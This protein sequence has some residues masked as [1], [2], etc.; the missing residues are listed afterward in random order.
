FGL[1]E[2]R[3]MRHIKTVFLFFF[4]CLLC[5]I[6]LSAQQR[7]PRP[8]RPGVKEAGVQR[9]MSSVTPIAVFP[10]EGTPDWQVLTEDS[11]W[12]TNGPKN[13]I[14]R[15]DVKTNTVAAVIEVG[16]RPCSGLAAGF[17][18]IWVPNCGDNTLSRIDIQT[19]RVVAT[20]PYGP[21]NS[22]GGLATSP[23]SVWMLTDKKGLLSRIDPS[24]N[25]VT[26]EIQVPSGSFAC[27]LGEDGAIWMSSTENNLVSRVDPAT[28]KVTDT[29]DVGPQ[30]RFLT[31]GGGSI[32]TLN[33]GDGTISRVDVKTRKL[34][35]NIQV[36]IPGTGGE[37]AFG[38][39]Y[40]WATVFEIPISQIDPATNKVVHQ[41][42]GAGGDS[43]RAGFGTVWLSN[44]RQGNL[45][46]IHPNQLEAGVA[47]GTLPKSWQTGGPDC[48]QL[49]KW[50][51]HEYNPDFYIL[52]ESGC[53]NFEKPFLYLIFGSERAL[54][55]D[56][57]AGQVDTATIV[58]DVV[59]KWAERNKKE[60]VPL[61]VTHSHAH[62][63]H[64]AGDAQFK[65][66]P[67][68]QFVAVTVP[69]IQKAFGIEHWPDG[70]GHVDLGGRIL[71]VIPIPGHN[72][73]SIAFYDRATGIL[74]TGDSVYPG[75]L[76][77]TDFPAFA[78]SNQRLVD[79]TRTIP[80]SHILGTHIEQARTPYLDYVRGTQYQPDEHAL[81][82]TRGDLLELN[83]ALAALHGKS[84]KIVLPQFTVVP[85][86]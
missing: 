36:G 57:G 56:T 29:V 37:I 66:K 28:N 43:I 48:A 75:R 17:G 85:R 21:A 80:V 4:V 39:G 68:V 2:V 7:Q 76:Y 60:S 1:P 38:E 11:V 8:P 67:N 78:A 45:W 33:Q 22:E 69:E 49:P 81:E 62:G 30:P 70:I 74:L 44:L 5:L 26:A 82:L 53:T 34:I 15:L 63:D 16:K 18:S 41:W 6:P 9:Q 65:D 47:V 40:L 23:D 59:A 32:W 64:V 73:A 52:R 14:H 79:F 50:Q 10:I 19:N 84:D 25:K 77:V 20:L 24:T 86:R 51:V 83:D 58:N 42:L 54:L 3:F 46:R 31:S 61:I 72:D 35:T 27:V 55:E 12:V 13:T 71:D